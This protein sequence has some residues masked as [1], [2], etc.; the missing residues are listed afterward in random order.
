MAKKAARVARGGKKP[1][2]GR[3]KAAGAKRT[4]ARAVRKPA[5]RVASRKA[6]AAPAA[7]FP[8]AASPVVEDHLAI[9]QLL[10]RYCHALD[11]GPLDEIADLFHRDAVLLP[12]YESDERYEGRDAVRGWY[13]RYIDN[14]RSKV[15]HLRHKI[16]SPLI[17]ITGNE[18]TSVCYLDADYVT[19][20]TDEPAVGLGRYDDKFVKDEGRWWFKERTIVVYYTYP[21][22]TYRE[23]RGR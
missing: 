15:R 22:A 23:G 5:N 16:E 9:Q 14:F 8:P 11:R 18:A 6:Q 3:K 12:R 19:T 13:G 4:V 20:E 2:A 10:H 1:A 7:S 21:L 17:E